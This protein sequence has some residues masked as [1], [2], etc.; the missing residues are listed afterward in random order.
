MYCSDSLLCYRIISTEFF[1]SFSLHLNYCYLILNCRG[2][3]NVNPKSINASTEGSLNESIQNTSS[4]TVAW[5][6]RVTERVFLY[7]KWA[8]FRY[9]EQV[10]I[11][12]SVQERQYTY[13][14]I[15]RCV[16]A[17]MLHKKPTSIAHTECMFPTLVMQL[18]NRICHIFNCGQFGKTILFALSHKRH[19]F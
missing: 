15:C 7:V 14:W 9:D 13:K 2:S 11:Q 19:N 1:P 16:R 10:L 8:L 4:V 5:Y 6:W 12:N 17:N 3:S 18:A